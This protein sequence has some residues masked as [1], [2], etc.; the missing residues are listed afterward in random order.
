MC[1]LSVVQLPVNLVFAA[2]GKDRAAEVK[3]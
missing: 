1:F 2:Y 3:G